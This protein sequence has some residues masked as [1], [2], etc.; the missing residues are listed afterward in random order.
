[1]FTT[2]SLEPENVTLY[3]K[4]D[5]ADVVKL[6]ILGREEGSKKIKRGEGNV[7]MEAKTGPMWPGAK[8]CH[9]L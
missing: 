7:T 6:R 5:F 9:S 3:S 1:M 4:R 2:Q 8:E